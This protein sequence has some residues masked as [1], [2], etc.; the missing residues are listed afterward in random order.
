MRRQEKNL[1]LEIYEIYEDLL[2]RGEK[3]SVWVHSKYFTKEK[4]FDLHPLSSISNVQTINC[5]EN[6][7]FSKYVSDRYGFNNPD[8]VWENK[9]TDYLIIGDSFARS[10]C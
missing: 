8:E 6:G 9:K 2:N 5:N 4:R 7:Y 3:I 1:I 10:V